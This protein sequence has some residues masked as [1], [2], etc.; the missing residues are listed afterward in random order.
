MIKKI[1]FALLSLLIAVNLACTSAVTPNSN[2][3]TNTPVVSNT[4]PTNLP[5]GL[6]T[7]QLPLSANSTPGIP[8]PKSVNTNS[9]SNRASSTPGIPD[10][11]KM[12]K[13]PMPKNTPPIPGI[14]DEETLKKQMNTPV[15]NRMMD[16]KPP[17][18]ESNSTNRPNN[19]RRPVGNSKPN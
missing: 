18:F 16:R 17:E 6:S 10:T 8:D 19:K 11:T 5:E 3:N 4:N 7:N 15:S 9:K 12:G 1:L 14:P 13:T 2:T